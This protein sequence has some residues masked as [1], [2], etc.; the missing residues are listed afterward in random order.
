MKIKGTAV[1]SIPE[2]IKKK[3]AGY[4]EKWYQEMPPE[5]AK[6][7]QGI[8]VSSVW[9]PMKDTLIVPLKTTARLFYNNNFELAARTMGRFSAEIALTGVYKFFIKVGTPK[10]LIDR[11]SSLMK[12][13]FEP[14]EITVKQTDTKE[15]QFQITLF[16]EADEVVEWNIAGWI[17]KALEISGCKNVKTRVTKSLAR[18]DKYSEIII[19]WE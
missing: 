17:D 8:I 6:I 3:H 1:H 2:F 13:Y 4:L 14:C 10:F 15:L 19:T 18:G 12:T 16:P 11:A 5:S 7:F 9:Y